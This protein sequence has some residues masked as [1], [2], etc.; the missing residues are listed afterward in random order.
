MRYSA[1]GNEEAGG[2]GAQCLAD[3]FVQLE[4]GEHDNPD[5]GQR[6]VGGDLPG[7]GDEGLAIR[8]RKGTIGP[9]VAVVVSFHRAGP[10]FVQREIKALN[11]YAL[12]WQIG[13]CRPIQQR[14][15]PV[16][17]L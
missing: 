7:G 16:V 14:A 2:A 13:K 10:V 11:R 15:E 8:I 17:P 9:V 6:R 5:S 1:D 4:G 3:V 12:A